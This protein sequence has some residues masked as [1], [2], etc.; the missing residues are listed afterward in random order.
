[1]ILSI[2][3]LRNV[4]CLLA[5]SSIIQIG[6]Y[7]GLKLRPLPVPAVYLYLLYTLSVKVF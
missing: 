1:M 4:V 7:H 5:T 3:I 6:F 2:Y